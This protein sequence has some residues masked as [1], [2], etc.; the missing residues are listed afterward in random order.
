M[1]E[2]SLLRK[3]EEVEGFVERETMVAAEERRTIGETDL[4]EGLEAPS[5]KR[6]SIE[7]RGIGE[8][9]GKEGRRVIDAE[10]GREV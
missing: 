8:V 6:K 4:R 5:E 9:G 3:E 10:G 7:E 2:E 1:R